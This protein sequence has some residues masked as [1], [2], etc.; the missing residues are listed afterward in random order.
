MTPLPL[1][2]FSLLLAATYCLNSC[3][4]NQPAADSAAQQANAAAAASVGAT[5]ETEARVAVARY[6]QNQPNAALYQL[7]SA[8]A[9]DVQTHWQVLV[10]RTDWAK[11]M[12]NAAAF[13]VDKQ[14]GTVTTL[15]VR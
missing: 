3:Q 8:R 12:P 2:R 11:R 9:V 6:V 7:D 1:L 10:P 13:E 4:L 14:T 15:A 5:T